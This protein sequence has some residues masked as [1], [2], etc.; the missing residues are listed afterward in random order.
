MLLNN[1]SITSNNQARSYGGNINPAL[2]TDV[3]RH[4][5]FYICD[6]KGSNTIN[7]Y[8]LPI[9]YKYQY[10]L[11][12]API[13]GGMSS[14][15]EL[16]G[17]VTI[18]ADG[19]NGYPI[20]ATIDGLGEISTALGGLIVE[21]TA[22][23]SAEGYLTS[24]IVGQINAVSSLAGTSDFSAVVSALAGLE[25]SIAG[26]ASIDSNLEG[27]GSMSADIYVNQAAAE[28]QEIVDA[29]W[30]AIA[31]DYDISGTMGE[32]LN[33]AGS[34]GDPWTTDLTSYTTANTAGK[35]LKDRLSKLQFLGLK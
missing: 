22:A 12:Y 31:A 33:G 26:V 1:Y 14:Y 30:N 3:A 27:N 21:L 15:G 24:S 8:S 13:D 23:L 5:S 6:N 29:I 17:T 18:T 7:A 19:Q 28:V 34:A 2:A 4:Y 32:K 11:I 25:A 10:A 16:A 9:G 20:T 35:I